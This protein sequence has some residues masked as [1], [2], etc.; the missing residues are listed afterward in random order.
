M[1]AFRFFF[2]L[3]RVAA[4]VSDPCSPEGCKAQASPE[5][6]SDDSS[7]FLQLSTEP[8]RTFAGPSP[9][10][11]D[12]SISR[13]S[14]FVLNLDRRRQDKLKKMEQAIARDAGWMCGQTCRVS[15]PDGAI[16]GPHAP[17][18]LISNADW[19][20]IRYV[21][22]NER[23][24][25]RKLTPGA[26]ALIVGH[27]LMWEHALQSNAEFAVVMED[28]LAR[29]H[30][31][32]K[33][34]MCQ[35]MHRK[36]A[37]Q[38][39]D[40]ILLQSAHEVVDPYRP[41]MFKTGDRINNT[42]MYIIKLEAARKAL[43]AVFPIRDLVQLDEPTSAFWTHLRGGITSPAVADAGHGVTDVQQYALLQLNSSSPALCNIQDC[44][45]L[46]QSRMLVPELM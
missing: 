19:Q 39:W 18:A 28:D 9:E 16:L 34:F 42:G 4:A 26:V 14:F 25:G 3:M 23:I 32:F 27:G 40:F 5:E 46:D 17:E 41:I 30:P 35:L 15:A 37:Q 31:E 24:V 1:K 44:A 43:A 36:D 29:F 2:V 38:D 21:N 7:I 8:Q 13:V 22:K 6:G 11:C 12:A 10:E 20:D 33:Q 45:P